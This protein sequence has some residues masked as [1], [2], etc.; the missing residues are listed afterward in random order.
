[1][2]AFHFDLTKAYES[3]KDK[4]DELPPVEIPD[5]EPEV[6]EDVP[7]AEEVEEDDDDDPVVD[8]EEN[9]DMD[10]EDED[11]TNNNA[12]E[13]PTLLSKIKASRVIFSIHRDILPGLY[14]ILTMRPQSDSVHKVN[15]KSLGPD[16]DEE[17]LMKVPVALTIVQ[18]LQKLPSNLLERNLPSLFTKVCT[19]CRSKLESV[20]KLTRE[21][22]QKIMSTLGARY[23]GV[24][25]KEM[26]TLLSRGFQAHVLAFTLHAVL[27]AL[28]ESFSKGDLDHCTLE[29]VDVFSEDLFGETAEEKDV[30]KIQSKVAEARSQ[31][32]YD[33]FCILAQYIS[34]KYLLNLVMPAKDVLATSLSHKLVFKASE[35]LRHIALGLADNRFVTATSLLTFAYGVVSQSISALAPPTKQEKKSKLLIP[36][37]PDCYIIPKEPRKRLSSEK[38]TAA[39]T[40]ANIIVE[41]GLR[42]YQVLL[43]RERLRREGEDAKP[44]LD[45]VVP[46]MAK[47]LT[48]EHVKLNSLSLQCLTFLIKMD[49]PAIKHHITSVTSSVFSLLHKYAAQGMGKGDNYELVLAAFKYVGVLLRD[50]KDHTLLPEQLATLLLYVEQDL[51]DHSRQASAFL[52]LKAILHRKLQCGQ[53]TDVMSGVAK[54][55]F[56]SYHINVRVQ[57]KQAYI[58]YLY[59]YP[60]EKS[61]LEDH[62]SFILSQLDYEILEGRDCA[63]D[64]IDAILNTFPKSFVADTCDLVF[65]SLAARLINEPTPELR[66][67]IATLLKQLVTGVDG[68][69]GE[70]LLDI[71]LTWMKDAKVLFKYTFIV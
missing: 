38:K 10:D 46:L 24:L 17:D 22:L 70:K 53:L 60:L 31:K 61:A 71:C 4:V 67:K 51:H 48:S 44:H 65:V 5:V 20:R 23:L 42:L 35:C 41:F 54:L 29:L 47:C 69:H 27:V 52:V 21:T 57:A 9:E 13:K 56:T 34:E 26:K 64:M 33:A 25:T 19:F 28:R 15:R 55:A 16:R 62:L 43:K 18:L 68:N 66:K 8:E 2:Q 59:E 32:S 40:N 45:A 1:M 63:L 3:G 49:L 37:K 39:V 11:A 58:T 7:N 6:P 30:A 36:E 12:V 14:K 50:V